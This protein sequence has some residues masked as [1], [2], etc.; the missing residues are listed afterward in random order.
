[1]VNSN[2]LLF[3]IICINRQLKKYFSPE[4]NP[5]IVF[6]YDNQN[7]GVIDRRFSDSCLALNHNFRTS[8]C[9]SH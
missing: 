8:H 2:L 4:S 5:N 3:I 1:M 9:K 6:G 7:R